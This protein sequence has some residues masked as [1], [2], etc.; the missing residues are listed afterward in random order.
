[1]SFRP[2]IKVFKTI[3][4]KSG[5][6]DNSLNGLSNSSKRFCKN[7]KRIDLK[8]LLNST[9]SILFKFSISQDLVFENNFVFIS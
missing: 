7:M 2:H 1:M 9:F 5:I 8:E 4:N 6:F 3:L